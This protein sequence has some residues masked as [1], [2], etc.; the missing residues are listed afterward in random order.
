MAQ[1]Y[2]AMP[3]GMRNHPHSGLTR[4]GS[5]TWTSTAAPKY[6]SLSDMLSYIFLSSRLPRGVC[7]LRFL[8]EL[9]D[10]EK[11]LPIPWGDCVQFSQGILV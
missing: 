2:A 10:P 5:G 11:F 1:L 9:H 3:C 4:T 7:R 6:C 8:L